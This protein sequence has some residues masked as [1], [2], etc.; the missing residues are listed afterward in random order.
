MKMDNFDDVMFYYLR[1]ENKNQNDKSAKKGV[2]FGVVAVRENENGTVNRGVSICSPSDRY[3]KKAGRGI[4]LKRLIEA[5]TKCRSI[6]FGNY[7]GTD[8]KKKITHLPFNYKSDFNAEITKSEY[9]MFH[10][11]EGV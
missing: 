10:K 3:N 4:A 1:D 8:D 9:R 5:E 7:N 2:P 6:P 11:P